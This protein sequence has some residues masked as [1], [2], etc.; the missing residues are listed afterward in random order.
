MKL[1]WQAAIIVGVIVFFI[2]LYNKD[3][4]ENIPNKVILTEQ[5]LK[6]ITMFADDSSEFVRQNNFNISSV[7]YDLWEFAK[8]AQMT[9]LGCDE[10]NFVGLSD[11][12]TTNNLIFFANCNNGLQLR[13]VSGKITAIQ[14]YTIK[15]NWI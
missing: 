12:S 10:L 5:Q 14:K 11:K 15:K 1:V 8:K 2:N 3:E 7:N 9:G 4:V 6:D 13:S